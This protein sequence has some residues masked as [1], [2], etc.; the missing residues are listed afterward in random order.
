MKLRDEGSLTGR[1]LRENIGVKIGNGD[2]VL[3]WQDVWVG[4]SPFE[5]SFPRLYM[6]SNQKNV[7]VNEVYKEE[8]GG[9][10]WKLEF[11]R[12]LFEWEKRL[13]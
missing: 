4:K 10:K 9:S 1:V 2:Q 5:L 3:F 11:R 13:Y 8:T 12:N 7:F 6:L